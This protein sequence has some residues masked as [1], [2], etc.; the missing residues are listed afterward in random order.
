[1]EQEKLSHELYE[2]FCNYLK[3]LVTKDSTLPPYLRFNNVY[4]IWVKTSDGAYR[5]QFVISPPPNSYLD[6]YIPYG[7]KS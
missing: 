7:A 1:M 4:S 2:M 6:Y 5:I 3:Q